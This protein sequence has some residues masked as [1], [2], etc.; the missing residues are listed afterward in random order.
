ML[1]SNK[2]LQ[3]PFRCTL[4][5]RPKSQELVSGISVTIYKIF[6]FA[7]GFRTDR[8]LASVSSPGKIPSCTID[9]AVV[10]AFYDL[11]HDTLDIT[12]GIS[13]ESLFCCTRLLRTSDEYQLTRS[14]QI[15][16]SHWL[17]TL[18]M[19]G[20]RQSSSV[21]Y[22]HLLLALGCFYDDILYTEY[23]SVL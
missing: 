4:S 13:V 10:Q 22:L 3:T 17:W 11:V 12:D 16:P 20:F 19:L 1:F 5:L 21:N 14:L 15:V 23:C 9:G 2:S 8:D 18:Q 6:S 7:C